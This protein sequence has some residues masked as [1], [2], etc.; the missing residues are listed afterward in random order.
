MQKSHVH[1][2]K[3]GGTIEFFDPL[4]DAIKNG[5]YCCCLK[6]YLMFGR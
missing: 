3:M 2:V 1:I 5:S 4:Y 6:N